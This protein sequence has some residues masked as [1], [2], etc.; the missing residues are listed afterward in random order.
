MFL[1]DTRNAFNNIYSLQTARYLLLPSVPGG[2]DG[3]GTAL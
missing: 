1:F 2:A 3:S